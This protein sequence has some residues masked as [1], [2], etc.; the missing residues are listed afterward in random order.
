M[1]TN[2]QLFVRRQSGGRAFT[3]LELLVTIGI[4]GI[5]A[6]LLLP[7]LSRAKNK[8]AQVVDIN[9]LKQQ[10]INLHLF[11]TDNEDRL[12]WPNWA[13]GDR[14]DRPGWLYMPDPSA[15]GP[16]R[17]KVETGSF[18]YTLHNKKLYL[19]P[20][21]KPDSSRQQQVS[22]YVMNGAVIGYDRANYPPVR[23]SQMLPDD[24]AF[25]ETDERRPDYFNDGASFPEEGVS[26]RHLQGAIHASFGGTVRYI[27]LADWYRDVAKTNRNRLWC[28]P[29]SPNGR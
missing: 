21:D 3:L 18:R 10:V 5:L 6:G 12:P 23:M 15:S 20:M 9:N 19:C 11:A 27:K 16:A 8:G 1:R 24:V 26:A 17:F 28:Y 14:P 2:A 4:I 13:S 29:D 7:V 25:W 22:S